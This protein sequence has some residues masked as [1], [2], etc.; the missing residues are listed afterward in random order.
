MRAK[1]SQGM[2][3]AALA[4][5]LLASG[6]C[7][8]ADAALVEAAKKE[9]KVTWYTTQIVSQIVRPTVAAFE[10]KYGIKVEYVRANAVDLSMR[11]STEAK[12]GKVLADVV[13]G[14]GTAVNLLKEKL[15]AKYIPNNSLPAQF[16]DPNGYWIA[17]NLYVLSYG[18]NTN[19]VKKDEVPRTWQDLLN[20]KW[21]GQLVWNS[22]PSAGAGQGFIGVVLAEMGEEKG[23]A[24][25]RELAK[26]NITGLKVSAR[27]VL[28]RVVAGE[29]AIAI[30]IFNNHPLVSAERGAP[31]AFS[32]SQPALAVFS[33]AALTAGAPNPNAGKLLIDFITSPEGQKVY[34]DAGELPVDPGVT[35]KYPQLRPDGKNYRAIYVSPDE[36]AAKLPGWSKI[37]NQLFR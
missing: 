17:T 23:M 3:I 1:F 5:A 14:T 28:D 33:V 13:D 37:F 27:Q 6:G 8:A 9:G 2:R 22:V 21:K 32:P 25:L 20:P 29:Y 36:L 31:V 26:Q 4:G 7:L 35:P 24:Y 34:A 19:L 30:N 11:V 10:K 18:Y 16:K 12:A 15:I